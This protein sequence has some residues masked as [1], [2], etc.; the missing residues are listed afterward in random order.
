[1]MK[2]HTFLVSFFLILKTSLT[3][4]QTN[5]PVFQLNHVDISIDSISFARIMN[6]S[7]LRDS[8]AFVKVFNDSTGS[9][10]LLLG[11]ESFIHLLPGKGFFKDRMGA[12]LLVHHSF[13]WTE[14]NTIME[15]LQGFTEDSLYNRPYHSA[16]LNIDYI[17]VYE[18]PDKRTKPLKF[19]P[20][21]QNNSKK[22][23]Q[24]WGYNLSD[25]EEGISQK[26]YMY[27]YVSK[28]TSQKLFNNIISISVT[29]TRSE[30]ERIHPLLTAYGYKK[31]GNSFELDGSPIINIT[32]TKANVRT[33]TITILLS[34]SVKR[35]TVT[36]SNNASLLLNNNKAVFS[37]QI[38]DNYR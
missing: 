9:E 7:F 10:L 8:F 24:S 37:Y 22:D 13:R 16:D 11:Q 17:N 28:E 4:A 38:P 1:M 29:A 25:L 15:Y 14:T 34:N 36:L 23:Y 26:K 3:Q 30:L 18:K 6:N 21:L 2:T 31:S 35:K 12:C 20:I 5:K 27:D 19:I 32:K 33:I